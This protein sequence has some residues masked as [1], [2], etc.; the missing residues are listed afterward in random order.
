MALSSL[1]RMT[2][3]NGASTQFIPETMVANLMSLSLQR[4]RQELQETRNLEA[5]LALLH[6]I[7]TL[8]TCE[9]YS[10]K[11]DTAWRIHVEGAKALIESTAKH[12]AKEFATTDAAGNKLQ[13]QQDWLTSRWYF[14]VEALAALT[15]RGLS[16]GQVDI[17]SDHMQGP[18]ALICH[19]TRIQEHCCLDLYAGYSSDL[20]TA[21][22]EIG[23]IAWERERLE[24]CKAARTHQWEDTD[25]ASSDETT[26]V[27]PDVIA[28]TL[29][30]TAESMSQHTTILSE[31]DIE[32][33]A[34]WLEQSI[35]SMISRDREG[36]KI[37]TDVTLS[38]AEIRQF[39]ACNQAYQYSALIHI[40]RRVRRLR[41]DSIEVQECVRKIIS[42][43]IGILPVVELSPW[44][45][46]T[47]PLFTAG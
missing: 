29:P 36:L 7:K 30:M 47:T 34:F 32:R 45:L 14:S 12:F 42:A 44:A 43:V 37:P 23:A 10:G 5:R 35:R 22:K 8:C 31:I 19:N 20:N 33:E 39:S 4:L 3:I 28:Q 13:R 40:Y 16:R 24:D 27:A 46:L 9:I 41:Q 1:H 38:E 15:R 18:R 26:A 2:I 21:F 17:K 6:T 11:A 25:T